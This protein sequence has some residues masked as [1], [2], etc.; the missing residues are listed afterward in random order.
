MPGGARLLAALATAALLAPPALAQVPTT[1]TCN[2]T[3]REELWIRRGGVDRLQA[4]C[5]VNGTR[6]MALSQVTTATPATCEAARS[7]S[8][9]NVACVK[10]AGAADRISYYAALP[11]VFDRA[12]LAY[13][14][15]SSKIVYGGGLRTGLGGGVAPGY[16]N[17]AAC[18]C[19]AAGTTPAWGSIDLRG[20]AFAMNTTINFRA[21][22]QPNGASS[23]V[24]SSDNQRVN[25][26]VDGCCAGTVFSSP[27]FAW[28]YDYLDD[29]AT[30]GRLFGPLNGTLLDIPTP[31]VTPSVT[32]TSSVT[33]SPTPSASPVA[34][35]LAG[36]QRLAYSD[37]DG[38]VVS[39]LPNTTEPGCLLA[40]CRAAPEGLCAAYSFGRL[41][42]ECFLRVNTTVY[43][44]STYVHAGVL[45]TS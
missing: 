33:A 27:V 30:A 32:P 39:V 3:Q 25:F 28:G 15:V 43:A 36:A 24:F 10:A 8:Y 17:A 9:P 23:V 29:A 16:G 45:P 34:A 19:G 20:T 26:A 31:S 21:G 6:W 35:C 4:F 13:I 40:C 42:S 38:D 11:I 44:P 7:A 14:N 1:L 18:L 12:G 5:N 41:T 2:S 37:V 22:G